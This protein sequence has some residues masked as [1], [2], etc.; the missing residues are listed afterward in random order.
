MSEAAD[1][2]GAKLVTV[3]RA[4]VLLAFLLAL[5]LALLPVATSSSCCGG[6]SGPN[7]GRRGRAFQVEVADVAAVLLLERADLEGGR[8]QTLSP[9]M[10]QTTTLT[11]LGG[12]ADTRKVRKPQRERREEEVGRRSWTSKRQLRA[13]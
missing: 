12:R 2:L 4:L 7:R 5:L 3:Q 6:G 1:D 13:R 11:K 9:R 8:E 10:P